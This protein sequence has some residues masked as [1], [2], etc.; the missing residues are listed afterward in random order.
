MDKPVADKLNP[1]HDA[2]VRRMLAAA[3]HPPNADREGARR[4]APQARAAETQR[5][6]PSRLKTPSSTSNNRHRV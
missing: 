5:R 3:V 4:N 6:A 1:A 2:V